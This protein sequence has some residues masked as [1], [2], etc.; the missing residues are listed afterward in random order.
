MS[1]TLAILGGI[2]AA[3]GTI[4]YILEMIRGKTKPR[5]VT[6]LT[7]SMLTGVA[8]AAAFTA[9]DTSSGIFALLGALTTGVI[10]VIG[11]K[12]GDRSFDPLDVVCM[13]GVV[14]GLAL[15]LIF[16]SPA[17][18]VWAAIV[19]DLVGFVPTFKHAWQKPYEETAST[20]AM[21]GAGG[22]LT[23]GAIISTG[24]LTVTSVGYPLYA[25][26]SMGSCALAVFVRGKMIAAPVASTS[27]SEPDVA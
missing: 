9:G 20:F 15:W 7:W 11:L 5:I 21:V 27:L 25:A 1:F 8:A 18:G 4:P 22:L 3:C 2:L 14:V 19:I 23:A 24:V 6:W 10:V 17:I 13:I 12:V 16:N 26:L